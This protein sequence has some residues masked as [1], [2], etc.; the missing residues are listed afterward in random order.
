MTL[1]DCAIWARGT[2]K[3]ISCTAKAISCN[4]MGIGLPVVTEGK[5]VWLDAG[6]VPY[7]A[8]TSKDNCGY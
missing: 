3:A 8:M 5:T 7:S 6:H 4:N 1:V 2:A